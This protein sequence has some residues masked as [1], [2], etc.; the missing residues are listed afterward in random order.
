MNF[1]GFLIS[2][3]KTALIGSSL[4]QKKSKIQMMILIMMS[5]VL[6]TLGV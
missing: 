2:A 4:I 6:G 1:K 3:I 5:L